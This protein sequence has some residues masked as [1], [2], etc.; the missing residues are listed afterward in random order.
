MID[1]EKQGLLDSAA[2]DLALL[3]SDIIEVNNAVNDLVQE[4]NRLNTHYSEISEGMQ[5]KIHG[6]KNP[7]ERRYKNWVRLNEEG[8]RYFGHI[9]P[10]GIIPTK[11]ILLPQPAAFTDDKGNIQSIDK[12]YRVDWN[13]LTGL[14]KTALVVQIGKKNNV[15]FD[16]MQA[17]FE[18]QGYIPL[19]QRY[20][21]GSG[22]TE[23][24]LF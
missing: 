11:D 22:T 4:I 15:P 21:S 20:A 23:R 8:K 16:D 2:R 18:K 3:G 12:I 17:E 9:F 10:S 13:Q 24:L 14:E 7:A 5:K 6:L 19:R 1:K